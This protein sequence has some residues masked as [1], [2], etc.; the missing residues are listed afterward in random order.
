ML[1]QSLQLIMLL[2]HILMQMRHGRE[3][4]GLLLQLIPKKDLL[5]VALIPIML[6]I[7]KIITM[8]L[9]ISRLLFQRMAIHGQDGILQNQTV[10]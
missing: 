1:Y 8:Q 6:D 5:K 10:L 2:L 3:K 9:V 4:L 7:W